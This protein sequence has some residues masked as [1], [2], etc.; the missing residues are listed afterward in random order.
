M[1]DLALDQGLQYFV[2]VGVVE[3]IVGVVLVVGVV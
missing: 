3:E 1:M 2:V